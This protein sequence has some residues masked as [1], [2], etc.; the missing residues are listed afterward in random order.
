VVI[1]DPLSSMLQ[2]G[3]R[4]KARNTMLRIASSS[5]S[6]VDRTDVEG[7]GGVF[8]R[9]PRSLDEFMQIGRRVKSILEV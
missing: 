3:D 6:P 7:L 2:A 5:D 9:K 1:I 8:A 4:Q